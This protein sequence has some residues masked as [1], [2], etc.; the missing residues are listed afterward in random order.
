MLGSLNGVL[1]ALKIV[2]EAKSDATH[3][4]HYL[5]SQV[6]V[7]ENFVKVLHKLSQQFSLFCDFFDTKHTWQ[8]S[9]K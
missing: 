9:A 8:V 5:A 4:L 3:D 1:C 7:D 2:N 6:T